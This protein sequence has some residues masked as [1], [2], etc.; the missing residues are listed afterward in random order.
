VGNLEPFVIRI[1]QSEALAACTEGHGQA[2]LERV[3]HLGHNVA[4]ER[5]V[6]E[7]AKL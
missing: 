1:G 3:L 4:L 2:R 7:V 5:D 6:D